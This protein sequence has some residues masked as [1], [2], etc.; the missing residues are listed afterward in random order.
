[1]GFAVHHQNGK[2]CMP[3]E[4]RPI[5]LRTIDYLRS[6]QLQTGDFPC[7][8][9]SEASFYC[10]CILLSTLLH[11][12][13]GYLDPHTRLYQTCLSD[14][15]S[16]QERRFITATVTGMRFRLR[17]FIAWHEEQ[18]GVWQLFGR[19]SGLGPD[20][21][22]TACAAVTMFRTYPEERRAKNRHVPA[23]DG[24]LNAQLSLHEEAN[25]LRFLALAGRDTNNR[26]SALTAKLTSEDTP[27]PDE[28]Q[29]LNFLS[30][31]YSVA[32]AWRQAALPGRQELANHLVPRIVAQC[33][34][35]A[36]IG[37]PLQYALAASALA[38]LGCDSSSLFEIGMDLLPF[39][40]A[41]ERWGSQSFLNLEVGSA[42]VTTAIAISALVR[43]NAQTGG[44]FC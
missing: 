16:S 26:T 15:L 33:Q 12:A 1:M 8:R 30:V 13:L 25:V 42:A 24:F 41:S 22:T 27:T 3:G 2:R 43:I 44:R 9:T 36:G 11:D 19:E 18:S 17:T 5:L 23:L 37:T 20:A 35:N 7:F 32:R 40:S 38:D 29:I 10:P 39:F 14:L 21:A 6:Q 31:A 34:A 4:L 28:A